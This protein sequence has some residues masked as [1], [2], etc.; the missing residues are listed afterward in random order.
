VVAADEAKSIEPL[1]FAQP[2][3]VLLFAHLMIRFGW[4]TRM[5]YFMRAPRVTWPGAQLNEL[6]YRRSLDSRSR[7]G[8]DQDEAPGRRARDLVYV[9]FARSLLSIRSAGG[10]VGGHHKLGQPANPAVSTFFPSPQSNH[11]SYRISDS[12]AV[13]GHKTRMHA[14]RTRHRRIHYWSHQPLRPI[15]DETAGVRHAAAGVLERRARGLGGAARGGLWR[16]PCGEQAA[17]PLC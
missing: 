7:N 15:G 8:E 2:H 4:R 14:G 3:A 5:A 9:L 16:A 17:P 11:K 13:S 12:S 6:Q 10:I 1:L